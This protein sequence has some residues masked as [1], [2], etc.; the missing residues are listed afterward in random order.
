MPEEQ[1][2]RPEGLPE[3]V[4][5]ADVAA[6]AGVSL[7]SASRAL[8]GSKGASA[9]VVAAVQAA[10]DRLGYRP[11]RIAQA[12]RSQSTGLIGI[13]V[14]G[15]SNP[16]FAEVI[17]ALEIALHDR[18]LEMVLAD[19]R[20]SVEEEARRVETLVDRK[21]D[22]IV[23]FPADYRASMRALSF[24]QRLGPLVQIDREVQGLAADYIG[25][26]NVLGI[27]AVLEHVVEI[28]A[29]RV[30][31]VS[32]QGTSSTGR[33]RLIAYQNEVQRISLLSPT[34]SILGDFSLE[35]GR[36]AV[37][38]LARR[39]R[40]PD[41]IVCGADIIALGV[42][43]ELA[44]H[45]VRVPEQVKVTGFD[46]ILFAELSDPPITTVRQPVQ[47]IAREAISLLWSRLQGDSSAP[48]HHEIAP[49]LEL[50]RSSAVSVSSKH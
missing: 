26:D 5:L 17:E 29:Q 47:A 8:S 42:I 41:A 39:R 20:S 27:R 46:G 45:G 10:A 18:Q 35:F 9:R 15:I 43:R 23:I 30:T 12:M 19:S 37:R 44:N 32:D 22:G 50:R 6:A 49:S 33:S 14:P 16:F 2:P 38:Q 4:L 21:V 11:D 28:G 1:L 3:R 36:A 25:V 24:A 48:L 13:V 31:F 34:P 7:A 40:L